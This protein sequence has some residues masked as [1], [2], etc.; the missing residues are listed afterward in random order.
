M[1]RI[2]IGQRLEVFRSK[3]T[4]YVDKKNHYM[5]MAVQGHRLYRIPIIS[6]EGSELAGELQKPK[7]DALS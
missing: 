2:W 1:M 4:W 6:S 3:H 7:M 5:N